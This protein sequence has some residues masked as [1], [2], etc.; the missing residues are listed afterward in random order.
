MISA[1]QFLFF[2]F[3]FGSSSQ[4]I[5]GLHCTPWPG[6]DGFGF[7]FGFGV[8]KYPFR[9]NGNGVPAEI[10]DKDLA[11]G[12]VLIRHLSN[13]IR[14]ITVLIR[15]LSLYRFCIGL[16][17][18]SSPVE[19]EVEVEVELAVWLAAFCCCCCCCCCCCYGWSWVRFVFWESN[20][21]EGEMRKEKMVGM[22]TFC[23]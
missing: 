18:S 12:R 22:K 23:R 17:S 5:F 13:L 4:N 3:F 11:V 15:S 16:S 2:F 7:G 10:V 6:K 21:G 19:V 8:S 20:R 14:H 9:E 1:L